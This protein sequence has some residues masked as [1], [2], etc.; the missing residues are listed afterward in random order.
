M[1]W[2]AFF[3]MTGSEICNI[4]KYF[5]VIPNAIITNK[6]IDNSYEI[7]KYSNCLYKI[8][9]NPSVKDYLNI[10]Q[11]YDPKDTII[12]LHGFLRIIPPEICDMYK[13][14]YNLHPGLITKYPQLKGKDPQVRAFNGNYEEYGA[15]IH[16]VISELDSGQ[17]IYHISFKK[18]PNNIYD[19]QNFI[20]YMKQSSFILWKK[21]FDYFIQ[22]NLILTDQERKLK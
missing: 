9:K 6:Y 4:I 1:K 16:R 11:S 10:L 8:P 13:N 21:L 2:I 5:N 19:F 18:Q 14:I 15:V 17:I 3:S 12:T 7:F 20:T 22:N